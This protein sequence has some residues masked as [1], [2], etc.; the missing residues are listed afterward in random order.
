MSMAI[1][2]VI[3]YTVRVGAVVYAP[4]YKTSVGSEKK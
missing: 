4:P 2:R 1:Y 3:E